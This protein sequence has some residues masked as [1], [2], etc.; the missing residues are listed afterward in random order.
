MSQIKVFQRISASFVEELFAT[1]SRHMSGDIKAE[2]IEAA[3]KKREELSSTNLGGGLAFPHCRLATLKE[4]QVGFFLL[5]QA[6][7][8]GGRG[9]D[10]VDLLVVVLAPSN[11]PDAYIKL[12][13]K[14]SQRLKDSQRCH[15]IRSAE[16]IKQVSQLIDL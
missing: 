6:I 16:N 3:L 12:M 5:E 9:K 11:Q 13:G 2:Q 15:R 7:A 8:F 10:P 1:I 4:F 14:L